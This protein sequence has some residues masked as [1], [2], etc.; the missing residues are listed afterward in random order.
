M[1]F[2]IKELLD[3]Y[4]EEEIELKPRRSPRP[5]K[6]EA[7]VL[8]KLEGAEAPVTRPRPARRILRVLP[9]AALLACLLSVTAYAV[10][11]LLSERVYTRSDSR[12]DVV[13]NL[14]APE[15]AEFQAAADWE[16]RLEE[17]LEAG[18]NDGSSD[19]P[20]GS[21][22]ALY[23][24]NGAFTQAARDALD[25]ILDRYGLTMAARLARVQDPEELYALTGRSAF[26]PPLGAL[27]QDPWTG[28]DPD[29][30]GSEHQILRP[31]GILYEGGSLEYSGTA[32]L[33]GD[34]TVPYELTLAA[35][36]SF[37]R[38]AGIFTEGD[39]FEEWTYSA[40][41]GP[42]LLLDLGESRAFV[43]AQLEH[44]AVFLFVRCGTAPHDEDTDSGRVAAYSGFAR[45]DRE[46]LE[47]LASSFDYAALDALCVFK[48]DP[49][50]P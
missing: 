16:R 27:G 8:A 20:E 13:L 18:E 32:L 38:G 21:R 12:G 39:S 28:P 11:S 15:S 29:I 2:N 33:S 47:E 19:F 22:E 43:S 37:I 23:A 34:R 48:C 35:N 46:L 49:R 7:L 24:Q 45:L 9:I 41:G 42:E 25:E 1:E 40:P 31:F 14:G 36:G 3:G 10:S 44:G 4:V 30:P 5:E 17:L 26:L 50:V 6:I